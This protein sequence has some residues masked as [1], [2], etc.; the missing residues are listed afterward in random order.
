MYDDA[1]C[2]EDLVRDLK[3]GLSYAFTGRGSQTLGMKATH[4]GGTVQT[5]I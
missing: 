4:L 3:I 1:R 2:L 5:Y